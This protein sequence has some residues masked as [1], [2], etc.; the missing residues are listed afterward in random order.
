MIINNLNGYTDYD[1]YSKENVVYDTTDNKFYTKRN[2][3]Y[4]LIEQADSNEFFSL[5][6]SE[7]EDVR[8]MLKTYKKYEQ[9]IRDHFPEEFL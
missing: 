9:I 5:S 8:N 3:T 1:D 2:S 4:N 6:Y 7:L